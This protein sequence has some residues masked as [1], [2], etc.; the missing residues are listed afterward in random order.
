VKHEI[1][2]EIILMLV[3]S[4]KLARIKNNLKIKLYKTIFYPL[5]FMGVKNEKN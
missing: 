4:I 2:N 5:V 1:K 3:F